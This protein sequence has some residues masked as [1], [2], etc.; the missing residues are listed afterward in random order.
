MAAG[1]SKD[2]DITPDGRQTLSDIFKDAALTEAYLN[3]AYLDLQLRGTNYHYW[4]M[5]SGISDEAHDADYPSQNFP[6]SQF[7]NGQLS[8]SYDPFDG[9][10]ASNDR[11]F[12]TKNWSGI[13]KTNIFLANA[14]NTPNLN[15]KPR[16][17][18]EAKVMRAYF[19]SELIKMYGPMPVI[20][21]Q[22][23]DITEFQ[24]LS[25]GTIAQ[26]VAQIVKDCDEA[27]AENAL[28]MRL[29]NEP[30][31]GRFTRAMAYVLK[32]NALLLSAS[33]QWNPGNDR[34]KWMDASTA[35]KN[36][37][38]DLTAGNNFRL[39]PNYE[40]YF[41]GQSDI[42]TNPT[43]RETIYEVKGFNE[44]YKFA[45]LLYLMHS[46]PELGASRAGD[47]PTQELVDAYDMK[48]GQQPILGYSDQDHLQPIINTASGYDEAHPYLNRDPRFY[49]TVYYNDAPFGALI[50]G[51]E[52]RIQAYIGGSDGISTLRTR[53]KTGY[54]LKKYKDPNVQTADAGSA[55]FKVMRLAELYLNYAEAENEVNGPSSDV[56]NALAVV[57]SR[58]NMPNV[59]TGLSQEQM[60]QRIRKERMV[61]LSFE[62]HRMWDVRRWKII[63]KTDK[64]TTGMEWTRQSDGSFTN[65]R[66]ISARRN[67]WQS[68]YLLWPIPLAEV[69]KLPLFVQNPDW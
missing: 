37:I 53:T 42:N 25:R 7:L 5:L 54:Y 68:K 16:L 50:K 32:A 63:D 41:Y 13:R 9:G 24:N 27:I 21:I 40:T 69:S 60:R 39:S 46:I 45:Q 34:Q 59:E 10:S 12:Y 28:P 43:D 62:E 26:S 58:V 17:L 67:A 49:Y 19:Y 52:F 2:L 18:A 51:Q 1:C 29:V 8:P 61:E 36:A 30:E 22:F 56:Y 65:R 11:A 14:V 33:P 35:S 44:R 48:N 20:T 3:S 15:E 31:R 38:D 47:C 23:E 55:R 4:T 66:I 64:L 57:R 6:V